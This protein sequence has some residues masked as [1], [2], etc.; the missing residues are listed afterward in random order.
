MSQINTCLL[1]IAINL[2]IDFLIPILFGAHIIDVLTSNALW[3]YPLLIVLL[4][5]LFGF[6]IA[7]FTSKS[8]QQDAYKWGQVLS[9]AAL[10]IMMVIWSNNNIN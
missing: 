3:I 6:L 8:R 5:I 9:S 1:F 10:L 4:G 7:L 2:F